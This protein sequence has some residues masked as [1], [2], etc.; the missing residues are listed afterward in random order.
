MKLPLWH[1]AMLLPLLVC[2]CGCHGVAVCHASAQ[3][4][5][6][7]E[8]STSESAI[9]SLLEG[10]KLQGSNTIGEVIM[11]KSEGRL[12]GGLGDDGVL[13]VTWYRLDPRSNEFFELKGKQSAPVVAVRSGHH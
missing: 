10:Y 8:T 1:Q 2:V 13:D 4:G 5:Y 12:L 11:A 6:F 9:I 3:H 7:S